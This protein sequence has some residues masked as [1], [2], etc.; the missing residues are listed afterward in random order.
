LVW[1]RMICGCTCREASASFF[2]MEEG[3]LIVACLSSLNIYQ[4]YCSK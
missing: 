3:F 4:N 2:D 1:S